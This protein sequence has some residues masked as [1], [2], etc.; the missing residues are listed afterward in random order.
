VL[1]EKLMGSYGTVSIGGKTYI[2]REQDF[3][4]EVTV[5]VGLGPALK[6]I[7]PLPGTADFWLKCLTRETVVG[8]ASSARR[9]KF[10]LGNSD[11]GTWYSS[12]GNGGTTDRVIDTLLFGS[13]QF[14]FVLCPYI[15]YSASA[16]IN[17][18]I[19]DISNSVPYTIYFNFRG[20]YLIPT[21]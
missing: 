2:E 11:G 15:Y 5:T 17:T 3:P 18:E 7:L 14:P 1:E 8:G 20:S 6:V 13:G 16:S 9:F 21:S 4:L 19:E 12:G 10:R